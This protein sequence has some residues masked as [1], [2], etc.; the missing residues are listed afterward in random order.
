MVASIALLP[1]HTV[2]QIRLTA[3]AVRLFLYSLYWL[4]KAVHD[5]E[6]RSHILDCV[7]PTAPTVLEFL[8]QGTLVRASLSL[9]YDPRR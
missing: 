8:L 3:L 5:S 7:I 2:K 6:Y 9:R 4:G 1:H